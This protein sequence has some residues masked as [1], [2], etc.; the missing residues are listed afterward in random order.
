MNEF[1]EYIKNL[2]GSSSSAK[3]RWIAKRLRRT[4]AF[5]AALCAM[6]AL[7]LTLG[8]L[9]FWRAAELS[10]RKAVGRAAG[11]LFWAGTSVG[12]L[13]VCKLQHCL[14]WEFEAGV[15]TLRNASRTYAR[16]G[17]GSDI[18]HNQGDKVSGAVQ[19]VALRKAVV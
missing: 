8:N 1:E 5:W 4:L 13:L 11:T 7:F 16:N 17:V 9:V 10:T 19:S 14:F 6:A 15:I 18:L 3:E 12:L 2:Q